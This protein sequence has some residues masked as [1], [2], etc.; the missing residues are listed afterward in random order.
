M[1]LIT[2]AI[3]HQ[4]VRAAAAWVYD[5]L[6]RQF[7]SRHQYKQIL[8][9]F[10]VSWNIYW[11]GHINSSNPSVESNLTC[12]SFLLGLSSEAKVHD[13]GVQGPECAVGG[14]AVTLSTFSLRTMPK[15]RLHHSWLFNFTWISFFRLQKWKKCAFFPFLDTGWELP[16]GAYS[17]LQRS[18]QRSL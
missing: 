13:S 11:S 10:G 17:G 18:H 1:A 8:G 9:S 14:R 16:A 3:H 6:A 15:G 2:N 12:V 4:L 7:M 5:G